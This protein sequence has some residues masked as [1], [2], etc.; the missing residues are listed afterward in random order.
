MTDNVAEQAKSVGLTYDFENLRPANTFDA[1]R[2]AKLAEQEGLGD[3]MSEQA[4]EIL[5]R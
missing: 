3:E 1:H 2:L 4:I 5:L